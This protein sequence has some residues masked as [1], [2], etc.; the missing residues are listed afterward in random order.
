MG[1]EYDTAN[2]EYGSFLDMLLKPHS[3]GIEKIVQAKER[4]PKMVEISKELEISRW[5]K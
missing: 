1:L 3:N 5:R 2:I 4:L